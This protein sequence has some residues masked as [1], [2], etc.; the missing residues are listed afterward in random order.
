[1]KGDAEIFAEAASLSS[2]GAAFAICTI[3]A[4]EGSVPRTQARLLVRADGSTLGTIGGGTLELRVISDAL[5]ALRTGVVPL[6]SPASGPSSPAA[7]RYDASS[8]GMLC[9]GSVEVHF[10]LVAAARSLLIVGAGHVGLA[11]ARLA[12]TAGFRI[13][14][15]D[16]RPSLTEKS[17]FPMAA[18]IHCASPLE[19]ALEAALSER[20]AAAPG[21]SA[22][23]IATHADD[24]RALRFL[25]G[26]RWDYLGMLGS[27]A[28]VKSL[29][30]RLAAEGV[31][32]ALRARLRAPVGLD[33]GA[34]TPEE[35]AVA[36]LAEILADFNSADA[37]HLCGCTGS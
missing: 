24:E 11:L 30:D 31:D 28:K 34:E 26:K 22:I 3:D 35:I 17:R 5:S 9:G 15:A 16:D 25:I 21:K 23:V 18:S 37:K 12:D 19:S 1:M 27:R 20:D 29:K 6:A 7:R 10:D 36:I 32:P 13:S 8:L 33:I 14:V 4:A 2:R